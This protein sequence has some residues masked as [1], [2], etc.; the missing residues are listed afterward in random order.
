MERIEPVN[1]YEQY[2]Y[3]QGQSSGQVVY[4]VRHD[5]EGHLIRLVACGQTTCFQYALTGDYELSYEAPFG[6]EMD[7]KDAELARLISSWRARD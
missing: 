5:S 1:D 2:L 4:Y 7:S 6:P 3:A